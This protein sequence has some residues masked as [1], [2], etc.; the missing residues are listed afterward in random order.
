[1]LEQAPSLQQDSARAKRLLHAALDREAELDT[2]STVVLLRAARAAA[3][4]YLPV[5]HLYIGSMQVLGAQE[6]LNAEY[7]PLAS[8][9]DPTV[10]C[11]SAYALRPTMSDA[12]LASL[13]SELERKGEPSGCWTLLA[14]SASHQMKSIVLWKR[15]LQL[16]PDA[17]F[18]WSALAEVLRRLGRRDE[19]RLVLEQA[20]R[21]GMHAFHMTDY[22]VSLARSHIE[23]GDSVRGWRLRRSIELAVARDGR[24]ALRM[25]FLDN[26]ARTANNQERLRSALQYMEIAKGAGSWSGEFQSQMGAG[27]ILLDEGKALPSLP[28][29]SRAI[30][31]ADSVGSASFVL[32]AYTRRGRA[33]AKAGRISDAERDLRHALRKGAVTGENHYLAEAWHNLAHLYESQGKFAEAS[34]AAKEFVDRASYRTQDGLR[35][36]SLRDAGIIQWKAGWHAAANATFARMVAVIDELRMHTYWAG[37]YFERRGDLQRARSYYQRSYA[38][39]PGDLALSLTGLVHVYQALGLLDSAEK[40]AREHDRAPTTPREVPLSPAIR[41]RRG[42]FREAAATLEEWWKRQ[43][44]QGNLEGAAVGSLHY[45]ELMLQAQRGREALATA[46]YSARIAERMNFVEE[47]IDALRLQGMAELLLGNTGSAVKLL[48]RADARARAHPSYAGGMRVTHALGEALHR[49]GRI[50]EAVRAYDRSAD[51]ADRAAGTFELD[52]DRARH[53]DRHGAPHDAALLLLVRSGAAR[54]KVEPILNRSQRR[55]ATHSGRLAANDVRATLTVAQVRAALRPDEAL[56]DYL[57]LDSLV[58]VNVVRHNRAATVVLPA[59]SPTVATL[60]SELRRTLVPQYAGRVDL[61]RLRFN[62]AAA[63]RL[64]SILVQ[65]IDSLL[66]GARRVFIVP[67]GPLHQLPFEALVE[68]HVN[69]SPHDSAPKLQER[70]LIDRYAVTYLPSARFL[71]STRAGVRKY[72]PAVGRVIL[73]GQTAPGVAAEIAAIKSVWSP[74]RTSTVQG[75][76]A[77][78]TAVRDLGA[79]DAA[80]L[81]VASHAVADDRDPMASHIELA[82]D[83]LND[84]YMH[85]GEIA[86]ARTR[87]Q[88]VVLS[89]CETISGPLFAGEGPMGLARAFLVSGA[90]SVVASM[91]PIGA[92]TSSLMTEFHR[93]LSAGESTATALRAA[94]LAL[95]TRPETAH[96]FYWASFVLVER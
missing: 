1:M 17:G 19:E 28:H 74:A 96:P 69:G 71:S 48:R 36:V 11:F 14:L 86:A 85:T 3:P 91:W 81:H 42:E 39:E 5:Q 59:S 26:S 67:D 34:R 21:R 10:R 46:T 79:A 12:R 20:L 92:A 82:A 94:K 75:A 72:A 51:L 65:P 58:A 7:A 44:A 31:I 16:S 18:A 29:F 15:L 4:Q 70:Y 60:T 32:R 64:H 93:G 50:Q 57:L 49:E 6:K 40:Y 54:A 83:S 52:L 45:A 77:T 95:R 78:E 68:G 66:H 80:I 22:Q 30:A 23:S 76:A 87:A 38:L 61:A 24:P 89:A 55:K 27:G 62:T 47:H 63:R 13:A 88:L 9:R 2:D 90:R 33:F 41:A 37:E 56:V 43:E 73:V 25:I 8:H 84:G 35:V 53:R